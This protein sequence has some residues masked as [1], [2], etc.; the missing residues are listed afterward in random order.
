MKYIFNAEEIQKVANKVVG[1]SPAEFFDMVANELDTQYPGQVVKEP[2]WF[3]SNAGGAMIIVAVFHASFKEYIILYGTPLGSFGHTGRY[4]FIEDIAFVLKGEMSY[5]AEGELESRVY[6]PGE[7]VSLHKGEAKGFRIEE[8]TWVLEYA[9]GPIPTMLPFGLADAIF[10]TLDYKTI[11]KTF[12][13]YG[14]HLLRT[15][16]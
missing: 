10:S 13:I 11:F 4:S 7:G 16:F 15:I 9:R 12:R 2:E 3:F 14:K 1:N 6:K 5:Y 8:D